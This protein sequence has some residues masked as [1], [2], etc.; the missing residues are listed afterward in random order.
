MN[1]TV[2]YPCASDTNDIQKTVGADNIKRNAVPYLGPIRSQTAPITSLESMLPETEATP[3]LPTSDLVKLRL[4]LII[5]TRGA[6]AKVETKV[7]KKE[8]QAK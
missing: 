3:A 2:K 4:S 5:G 1:R 8:L 7:V 6:A